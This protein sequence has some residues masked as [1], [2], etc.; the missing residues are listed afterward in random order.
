MTVL[1]RYAGE[2]T[3]NS[4]PWYRTL[5]WIGRRRTACL[6]ASTRLST[7]PTS[8]W[9]PCCTATL[10][11]STMGDLAVFIL[12]D[13]TVK[14]F[15]RVFVF[16]GI[17]VVRNTSYGFRTF[18]SR[19]SFR[20]PTIES[21]RFHSSLPHGLR[22]SDFSCTPASDHP[23]E[24]VWQGSRFAAGVFALRLGNRDALS[25]TLQDILTLKLRNCRKRHSRRHCRNK[26]NDTIADNNRFFITFPPYFI[27]LNGI[28][29]KK[30]FQDM[31]T[32]DLKAF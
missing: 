8:S 1:A 26:H 13:E 5:A 9:L 11:F 21:I 15:Y 16:S 6:T 10:G 17:P 22:G 31:V 14:R 30:R 18:R 19:R 3:A 25:L 2:D 27:S 29:I 7:L 4:T 24:I 20:T 23:L 12:F 32:H 28:N